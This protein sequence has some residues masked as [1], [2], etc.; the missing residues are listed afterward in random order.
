MTRRPL[1]GPEVVSLVLN[2]SLLTGVFFVILAIR[3][4]PESRRWELAGWAVLFATVLPITSLF[5]LRAR[6]L[7]SDV[8]MRVRSERQTVYAVCALGYAAG[9]GLLASMHAAWP[10]T[11]LMTLLLPNALLLL[12]LNR[13]WKVSI[14]ATTLAGLATAAVI[15][16]GPGAFP[17]IGLV[18]LAAWARWAAGAHTPGELLVGGGLGTVSAV[19]GLEAVRALAGP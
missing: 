7:L 3:F 13:Y 19:L 15:L 11:G 8:E 5:V 14:H 17:V 18:P 9:A 4:E 10:L 2:P 12:L 6:G 1:R 16:F